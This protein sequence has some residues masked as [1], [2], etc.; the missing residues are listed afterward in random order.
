V[1]WFEWLIPWEPP[2]Q[3]AGPNC[4]TGFSSTLAR[5]RAGEERLNWPLRPEFILGANYQPTSLECSLTRDVEGL[6]KGFRSVLLRPYR[7]STSWRILI[8]IRIL[9]QAVSRSLTRLWATQAFRASTNF[10]A[11]AS[12]DL[13]SDASKMQ[14]CWR[15]VASESLSR[16]ALRLG[17]RN[18]RLFVL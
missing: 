1:L 9:K 14:R 8:E 11:Y 2:Q 4:P 13:N 16:L 12:R 7:G 18:P 17:E 10:T 6:G 15:H 3:G 5:K